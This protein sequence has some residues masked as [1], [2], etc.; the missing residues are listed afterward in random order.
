MVECA[1]MNP[2]SIKE[3]L[4]FGWE[5]FKKDPWFYVIVTATL[6]IFSMLVNMLTSGGQAGGSF[7]GF[8]ISLAASAVVTVAYARLALT[9]AQGSQVGWDGLWAPE[10]FLNMLGATILQ[11]IIVLVGLVLLIIPGIIASLILSMTQLS[12]VDK[13]MNPIDA[14]KASYH[15][16]KKH[17]WLLFQFMVIL[18]LLNLAGLIALVVGLF[19]TLPVS[20]IAVAYVYKKLTALEE[21]M[22]VQNATPTP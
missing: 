17:L 11:S 5:T 3:A 2:F 21:P 10:H 9:A 8:I 16:T 6:T 19:V 13:K 15:L 12:V 22:V 1:H 4:T 18:V 7:I 20:L 14:L